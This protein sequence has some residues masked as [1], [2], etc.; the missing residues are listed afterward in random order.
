[1]IVW[2]IYISEHNCNITGST[3]KKNS[4]LLQLSPGEP[5]IKSQARTRASRSA[6]PSPKEASSDPGPL[7]RDLKACNLKQLDIWKATFSSLDSKRLGGLI[8]LIMLLCIN[9]FS[10]V[11][12]W[13]VETAPNNGMTPNGLVSPAS[14]SV[15]FWDWASLAEPITDTDWSRAPLINCMQNGQF[16]PMSSMFL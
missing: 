14:C 15:A 11:A 4:K 9:N 5:P 13:E 1:M 8:L 16:W 6:G 7:P 12:S 10:K 3:V 2:Y